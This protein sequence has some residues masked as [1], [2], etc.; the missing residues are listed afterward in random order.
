MLIYISGSFHQA[1]ILEIPHNVLKSTTYIPQIKPKIFEN[2]K[3]KL[4]LIQFKVNKHEY[5]AI[6]PAC[7]KGKLA[8]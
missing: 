1:L 5:G 7:S 2:H 6:I 3:L 8:G 4:P